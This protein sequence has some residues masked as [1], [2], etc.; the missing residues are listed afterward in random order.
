M[1]NNYRNKTKAELVEVIGGLENTIKEYKQKQNEYI[2]MGDAITAKDKEIHSLKIRAEEN[3]K[4]KLE[5]AQKR[6]NIEIERLSRILEKRTQELNKL[7]ILY[8]NILKAFQG[9]L[10]NAVELNSYFIK[11]VNR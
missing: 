6:N 4:N 5:E 9:S 11:E 2:F 1:N 8:G 3:L 10:D 7:I